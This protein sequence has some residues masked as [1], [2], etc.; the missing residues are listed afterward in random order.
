MNVFMSDEFYPSWS[1]DRRRELRRDQ[2]TEELM[3]WDFLKAR[4]LAGEKFRRQCGLGPYIVDFYCARIRLIIELDGSVH[5]TPEAKDYDQEREF[6]LFH[7]GYK[8][9]RFKN[10]QVRDRLPEVLK[11]I[12]DMIR[13]CDTKNRDPLCSP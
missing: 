4:R 2:T 5:N 10:F 1:L 8:M 12:Q 6:E 9:I 3:L 7:Q 11:S 13:E